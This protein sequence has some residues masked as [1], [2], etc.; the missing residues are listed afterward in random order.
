MVAAEMAFAEAAL[1]EHFLDVFKNPL[2]DLDA[3]KLHAFDEKSAPS[4]QPNTRPPA[5]KASVALSEDA[6]ETT[7][8]PGLS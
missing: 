4:P 8:S 3:C 1:L 5:V 6:M 2:R 7:K